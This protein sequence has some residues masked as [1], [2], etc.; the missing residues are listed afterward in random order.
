MVYT[1]GVLLVT[2]TPSR[3]CLRATNEEV[4]K[5]KK[6]EQLNEIPTLESQRK[7]LQCQRYRHRSAEICVWVPGLNGFG[8]SAIPAWFGV[9]VGQKIHGGDHGH[10]S[11]KAKVRQIW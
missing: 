1:I 4:S 10:Q 2:T 3:Q 8:K 7:Q 11:H 6:Q 5:R 9:E